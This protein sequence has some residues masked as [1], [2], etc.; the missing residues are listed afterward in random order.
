[1]VVFQAGAGS[2]KTVAGCLWALERA[3]QW[4]GSRGMIVA[5][6]Y[7]MLKHSVLPH[8]ESIAGKC[9]LT[10]AW[11][12]NRA[13]SEIR[14]PNGSRFW[15]RSADNPE[16]II[17][18]DLA[19][20]WGD[21]I[22]LWPE[23]AYYYAMGRLRQAGFPHQAAFTFTPKGRNWVWRRFAEPGE[24]VEIVRA[25]PADNPGVRQDFLERLRREYGEGTAIW[26]QEV[27]GEF[28]A[29]EGLVYPQFDPSVHIKAPPANASWARV[30]GGVDW[31]W[32]DPGVIAVLGMDTT[33]CLWLLE[34]E[35]ATG[36][37][38]EWWAKRALELRDAW[39]IDTFFCDPESPANMAA[40]AAAGLRVERA[41][42]E[43]MAGIAAVG[44]RLNNQQ[45]F[46]SPQCVHAIAEIQS[47]CYAQ[48]P[49][50]TVRS[51]RVEKRADHCMDAL[52]YAVMGILSRPRAGV[53][54]L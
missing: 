41:N 29:F 16:A 51:D 19:W 9:G 30:V 6:S 12:W 28:V 36:Q 42:N 5:A 20:L 32:T 24:G 38:V 44:S 1:V 35:Y 27:K 23:A 54:F 25:T 50:G 3:T 14:L 48:W 26:R 45:L 40:F 10:R 33:G 11:A 49:D 39:G 46:I 15:L 18:A 53:R 31:G 52:R 37:P 2:G 17:G 22:A 47:Y 8:L 7:P 13:D 34:E 21:E 43:V 4:R